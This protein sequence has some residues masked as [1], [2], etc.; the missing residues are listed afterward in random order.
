MICSKCGADSVAYTVRLTPLGPRVCCRR[1]RSP[2]S[3][4]SC[5]NP[6]AG[7]VLDHVHD[8]HGRSVEVSSLRQIRD[9]EKRYRFRSLVANENSADF[10]KPPQLAATQ[11][12]V[13]DQ[14]NEPW[15]DEDGEWHE[16][17]WLY[18]EIAQEQVRELAAEGELN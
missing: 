17:H 12:S 16:S 2:R 11:R 3:R 7:L 15:R 8:E 5:V 9:A 14:M 13:F 18:P 6:Y 1:C 4:P 10:D